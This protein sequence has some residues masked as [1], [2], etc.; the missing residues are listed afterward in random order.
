[1][2][3][4]SGAKI[5]GIA[6]MRLEDGF[7]LVRVDSNAGIS[8]YGKCGDLNAMFAKRWNVRPILGSV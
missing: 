7:C 1:M 5:T 6:A 8:G 3:A 2:G 4:G